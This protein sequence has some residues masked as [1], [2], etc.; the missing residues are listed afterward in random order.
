A[1]G[2]GIAIATGQLMPIYAGFFLYGIG[3]GGSLVLQEMIWATYYGRASLGM[4]RGG[5]A[6]HSDIRRRR[7]AILRFHFRCHGELRNL[8]HHLRGWS[9]DLCF[10]DSVGRCAAE[11]EPDLCQRIVEFSSIESPTSI[12]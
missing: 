6:H 3:L 9:F 10:F 12:R 7:R 4:V 11:A 8:V 5:Y 2:I 1:T